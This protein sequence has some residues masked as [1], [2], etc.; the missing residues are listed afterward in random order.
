MH[1][2][3]P[4]HRVIAAKSKSK[5]DG[6]GQ[7]PGG[8][9]AP[10]PGKDASPKNTFSLSLFS[11]KSTKTTHVYMALYHDKRRL[12]AKKYRGKLGHGMTE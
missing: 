10:G 12:E 5:R 4:T 11:L 7:V 3:I 1:S 6:G 8:K 2:K 9:G